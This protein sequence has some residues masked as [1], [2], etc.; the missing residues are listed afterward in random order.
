MIF[1]KRMM[2]LNIPLV[3]LSAVLWVSCNTDSSDPPPTPGLYDNDTPVK[4]SVAFAGDTYTE[5]DD[6]PSSTINVAYASDN[7]AVFFNFSTGVKTVLPHD[8]FDIAID[9]G[10]TIIANSGSYGSGVQVYKT[11][12]TDISKDFSS[13]QAKVKEYTFKPTLPKELLYGHQSA[14]NP[15]GGLDAEAASTV[16]L[17]KIQYKTTE[18][19]E[20]F[21]VVFS[22]TMVGGPPSFNITVVPGLGAGDTDKKELVGSVSGLTAGYGWLYFKLVGEGGPRV[23]NNGATWTGTGTAVPKAADWDILGTRTDELQTE[24]GVTVSAQM[25]VANRSSILLN[26]YKKVS[27]GVV[28]G[29]LITDIKD[30]TDIDFREAVDAIGYGWY[31]MA[32]MP[33][34]FSVAQNTYIIKIAEGKFAKFQPL[35]FNNG[36]GNFT[37][38]FA[39][40]YEGGE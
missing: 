4:E 20:Y 39:Y 2:F 13:E 16:C 6:Y 36:G 11:E 28:S 12:E 10:G 24:D 3:I 34:V 31:S 22:M 38:D 1:S 15:L 7:N 18:E 23:L 26:I 8:F 32:G 9:A 29:K 25:P 35:T 21:K 27:A 37:M 33:P 5:V 17:V 30:S 19:A 40:Y 14:V